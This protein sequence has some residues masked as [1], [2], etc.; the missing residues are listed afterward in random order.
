MKVCRDTLSSRFRVFFDSPLN[1]IDLW[2]VLPPK[3]TK[4][5]KWIYGVDGKYLRRQGVF[6]IHRD[7]T[8]K[9]N[10]FWSFR[11]SESYWALETDLKTLAGLINSSN[12][13][14]PL[15]AISDW[16]GAIVAAVGCHFGPIPHQRCLTHVGNLAKRLLP[17][18]SPYEATR[19]LRNISEQLSQISTKLEMVDWMWELEL[20]RQKYEIMLKEKTLGIGTKKKWWYTHGNLRRGFRLLTREQKPF[21]VYLDH[22][23]IPKT[24]NSLEGINSQAVQ[25]LGDH[26]GMKTLQQVSFLSWHLTFGKMK[27]REDIKKLWGLWKEENFRRL[28]TRI[29]T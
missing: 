18:N 15:G 8:N 5:G 10:L 23:L 13:N 24:N 16:K 29:P 17:E 12:G 21:F 3:T 1:P 26:R 11:S 9:E 28:P 4:G 22:P 25:K 19:K 7:V 20:W 14:Y 6:L 2:K 27:N